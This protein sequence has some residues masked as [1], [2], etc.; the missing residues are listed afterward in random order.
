[1]PDK[2][3]APERDIRQ[4]R[5]DKI[6]PDPRIMRKISRTEKA[7]VA[8][9]VKK[10]FGAPLKV[11]P[12]PACE[13]FILLSDVERYRAALM[14]GYKYVPCEIFDGG[15]KREKFAFSDA[16]ILINTVERAV[17]TSRRAGINAEIESGERDGE[18]RMTVTVHKNHR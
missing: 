12:A 7:R 15:M 10:C 3:A 6:F 18:Y 16:K 9:R 13:Q 14:L 2:A 4:I 17:E 1:M 11:A 5:T 8:A